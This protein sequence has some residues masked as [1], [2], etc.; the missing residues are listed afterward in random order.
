[1]AASPSLLEL[2]SLPPP[3][4]PPHDSI[5]PAISATVVQVVP[6]DVSEELMGK[7]MDTS[8]FGF[9]YDRSG[10]WSPLAL[11]PEVLAFA[12]GQ[13]KRRRRSWRRKVGW[14]CKCKL[15]RVWQFLS[16]AHPDRFGFFFLLMQMCCCW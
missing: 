9:D 5:S 3:P 7:F 15:R 2:L 6:V 16:L 4:S 12:A 8:E 14:H 1:M 10:L 13:A 11:R